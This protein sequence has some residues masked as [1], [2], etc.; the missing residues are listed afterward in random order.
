M[1]IGWL[2]IGI[3]L[4]LGTGLWGQV[5]KS[6]QLRIITKKL[7]PAFLWTPYQPEHGNGFSLSAKGRVGTR[8]WRI[9]NGLLPAGM[10]LDATGLI[11]GTPQETGNFE[12]TVRVNDDDQFVIQKLVLLIA[13]PL[14]TQW[15]SRAY[16]D[17]QSIEGSVKVSNE[18]G[19]DVDLTFIVLAVDPIGRATVI[20]YQH[21][22]LKKDTH[23]FELPFRD[24]VGPGFYSV[25]VDVIGE[26]PV[27]K[28]IFRARLVTGVGTTSREP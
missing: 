11:S 10:R 6:D 25:N 12:F 20:G 24:T 7:P 26:E 22:P 1:R 9:V 28:R 8:H 14:P 16:A 5:P 21:F 13:T 19:R 4:F 3:V 15:D 23:D 17:G 18:T 27:A 2:G